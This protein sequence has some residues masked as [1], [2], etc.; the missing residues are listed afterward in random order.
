M[1]ELPIKNEFASALL[2]LSRLASTERV[3]SSRK[4]SAKP[5]WVVSATVEPDNPEEKSQAKLING[6]ISTQEVLF[7]FKGQYAHPTHCGAIPIYF[8]KGL[9]VELTDNVESV[10]VQYLV[11]SP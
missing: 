7:N 4:V 2:E 1:K 6:E 3:T 5:V 9:Y 10:T 11:D 8:N